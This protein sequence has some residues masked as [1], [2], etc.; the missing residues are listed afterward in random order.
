MGRVVISGP[1]PEGG[2]QVIIEPTLKLQ[3]PTT[4]RVPAGQTTVDFPVKIVDNR[5][6]YRDRV[7]TFVTLCIRGQEMEFPGPIV[8]GD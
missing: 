8:T 5:F 3:M 2:L 1:A 4:V 6:V 7:S